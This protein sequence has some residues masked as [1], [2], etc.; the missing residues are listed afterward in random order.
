M[1][2]TITDS[3]LVANVALD[4][5]ID[6]VCCCQL[7]R[8]LQA[9]SEEE[10]TG[11]I[12][13]PCAICQHDV[14]SSQRRCSFQ[15]GHTYHESCVRRWLGHSGRTWESGCPL[16]C[17]SGRVVGSSDAMDQAVEA[18]LTD[19]RASGASSETIVDIPDVPLATDAGVTTGAGAVLD[20]YTARLLEVADAQVRRVVS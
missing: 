7:M 20:S 14:W 2:S 13:G 1:T 16:N 17:N 10:P 3:S 5:F 19:V 15:C 12:Y 11:H 9:S 4:S 8:D 6:C 18:S